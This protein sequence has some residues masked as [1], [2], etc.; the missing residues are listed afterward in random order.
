MGQTAYEYLVKVAYNHANNTVA[1]FQKMYQIEKALAGA[2]YDTLIGPVGSGVDSYLPQVSGDYDLQ[3]TIDK[4]WVGTAKE[5]LGLAADVAVTLHMLDGGGSIISSTNL[6][7]LAKSVFGSVYSFPVSLVYGQ[8]YGLTVS[9]VDKLIEITGGSSMAKLATGIVG[10][11]DARYYTRHQFPSD[12]A[13][14]AIVSFFQATAVLSEGKLMSVMKSIFEDL[15]DIPN[16]DSLPE[17]RIKMLL[18]YPMKR[19]EVIELPVV[20]AVSPDLEAWF[21]TNK[22]ALINQYGDAPTGIIQI[23]SRRERKARGR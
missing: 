18:E 21:N 16:G 4:G 13:D 9:I 1:N 11:G 6:G 20:T 5:W 7:K 14:S 12:V 17:F 19:A 15:A 22:A 8:R 10:L 23:D 3:L 2:A